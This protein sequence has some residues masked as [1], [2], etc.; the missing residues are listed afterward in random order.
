MKKN[1][2]SQVVGAQMVS[3]S[4]GSAFT[5]A[6]T[7]FVTGDAGTQAQGTV[8]SGACTHEGNG[9]HTYAPAQAETNYDHVAF[10]FTGS[11]AVPATVQIYTSFPQT[12]DSFARI[13]TNGASL[14]AIPWNA[15][16]DAEV[17]SEVDD[18]LVA[19]NLDHLVKAAVDTNFATTVHQDSVIGQLAD[20]GGGFDRTTDSLEA[21]RDRG[22]AAWITAT[23]FSTHSAA[24]VWSV[25]TRS[26]TVIDE[27]STTLD[28]DA[29]IRAAVGLAAA[30]LDTQLS[31]IDTNVDS[32]LADTGTDGVVVAAASKTGYRLSATGVDD[33]HDEAVEGT[34]TLRQSIRLANAALGGKASGLETTNALYRD[35]GDSKNRI[36]ATVDADGNRTAVTLD[37]T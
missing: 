14:T 24:D 25:V 3:A 9:F 27:D 20:N 4:D 28:L 5:G 30:D 36:D 19:Q 11:G 6:V 23:G 18:A 22:D 13:G 16:W 2:A 15:S 1:V 26:L 32:I 37:L 12:G 33:I 17:Q 10:T 7:V 34:T 29:T 35:L 31:T 8:G 21:I